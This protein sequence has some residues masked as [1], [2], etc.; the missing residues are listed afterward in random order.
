MALARARCQPGSL[1]G[2][3]RDSGSKGAEFVALLSAALVDTR[4]RHGAGA[5]EPY[6]D[7]DNPDRVLVWE[8]WATRADQESYMQWRTETGFAEALEPFLAEPP[9]ILH[10]NESK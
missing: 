6:V 3:L 10:L 9:R 8:K 1:S 7:S 2:A 4:A 5:M